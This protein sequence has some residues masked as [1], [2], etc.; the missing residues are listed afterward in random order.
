MRRITIAVCVLLALAAGTVAAQNLLDNDAYNKALQLRQQAQSAFENGDYPQ[1]TQLSQQSQS[2]AKEAL[3]IAQE[4]ALAYRATNWLDLAKVRIQYASGMNV[5]TRYP[6]V[7]KSA[8]SSYAT[9]QS[10]YAA[11][12]YEQSIAASQAVVAALH[13][14]LAASVLPKY[15]VVRLL[16]QRRDCFWRIAEYPF[17]YGDPLKWPLLYQANKD[18]LQDPNNPNLIQPGMVFVIPSIKGEV[19]EGTWKP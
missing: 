4:Q 7:W 11:K 19:R 3:A 13:G 9:A 14:I 17:V 8:Q 10:T 15:Y 16:P 1:S 6:D 18:K 5:P 12:Q 2:Y